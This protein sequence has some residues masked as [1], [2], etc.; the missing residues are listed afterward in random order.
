V[1]FWSIYQRTDLINVKKQIKK[2][3]TAFL[4]FISQKKFNQQ[5]FF[6]TKTKKALLYEISFLEWTHL[7]NTHLDNEGEIAR[8]ESAKLI[9]KKMQ[10]ICKNV[11]V[12]LTGDLNSSPDSEPYQQIISEEQS[13]SVTQLFD[14][15]SIS[16]TPPHG[17]TGTFTGFDILAKPKFPIDFIF[18]SKGISVLSHGTLSDSFDGY[19]PSDHYPVLVEIVSD[20]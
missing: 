15:R 8:L 12:I 20:F 14:A 6:N 16:Q 3:Y 4:G 1:L 13:D 9:K 11:P 19:L 2:Y 10:K 5:F 18:V 7:F 17:P